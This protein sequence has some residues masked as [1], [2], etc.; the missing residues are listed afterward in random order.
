MAR[1]T[2]LTQTV[3]EAA[4]EIVEAAAQ[5]A[6]SAQSEAEKWKDKYSSSAK[7]M[8]NLQSKV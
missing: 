2:P 3:E 8:G 5:A 7:I 6:E 4:R 1:T